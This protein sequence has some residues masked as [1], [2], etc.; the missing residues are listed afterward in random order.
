MLVVLGGEPAACSRTPF[1]EGEAVAEEI[2]LQPVRP[3]QRHDFPQTVGNPCQ[4]QT[5]DQQG[6]GLVAQLCNE[7]TRRVLHRMKGPS[8]LRSGIAVALGQFEASAKG[9]RMVCLAAPQIRSVNL[10]RMYVRRI[11]FLA[12]GASRT[13]HRAR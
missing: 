5:H 2:G 11:G 3:G 1:H 8:E 12:L 9:D 6:N 7:G 10:Y 4:K 13:L